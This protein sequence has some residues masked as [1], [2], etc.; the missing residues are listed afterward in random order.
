M[1]AFFCGD[2]YLWLDSMTRKEQRVHNQSGIVTG[3]AFLD[4]GSSFTAGPVCL[5]NKW[6]WRQRGVRN[7]NP[8]WVYG[9]N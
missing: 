4:T 5:C 9:S 3:I 1:V 2:C 8:L 7:T 6:L